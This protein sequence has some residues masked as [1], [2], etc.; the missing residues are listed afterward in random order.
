MEKVMEENLDIGKAIKRLFESYGHLL[1]EI[2]ELEAK[3]KSLEDYIESKRGVLID[4]EIV[5]KEAYKIGEYK[6]KTCEYLKEGK[7]HAW[8][9]AVSREHITPSIA[10]CAFCWLY[11]E[12]E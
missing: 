8:I 10:Y 1:K 11:R 9:N 7:C 4:F 5:S 2:K 12:G 6:R 3:I